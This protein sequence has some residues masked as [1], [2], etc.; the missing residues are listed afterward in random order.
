M[1]LLGSALS[2]RLALAGLPSTTSSLKVFFPSSRAPQ[3]PPASTRSCFPSSA[4]FLAVGQDRVTIWEVGPTALGA[5]MGGPRALRGSFEADSPV[6]EPWQL[7]RLRLWDSSKEELSGYN[8]AG[9]QCP[10]YQNLR[11]RLVP[12]L[13]GVSALVFR[14]L[15]CW[16][17]SLLS[18]YRTPPGPAKH[19]PRWEGI[20]V[21]PC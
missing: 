20:K 16:S 7:Q 8:S 5:G 18:S 10:L 15:C 2:L 17:P 13:P 6:L 1:L 19:P 4:G 11:V 12:Q 14:F 9:R 3:I 21:A